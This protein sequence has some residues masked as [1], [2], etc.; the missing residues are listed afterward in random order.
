MNKIRPLQDRVLVKRQQQQEV[1]SGGILI[2]SIAQ[3]KPSEGEVLA[4]GPGKVRADGTLREPEVKIGDV[5][6][7]GKYSG[8]E[9]SVDGETY[10]LMREDDILAIVGSR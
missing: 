10:V 2:P 6:M 4:V 1:S 7:F 8:T 9:I 3:E 5:V